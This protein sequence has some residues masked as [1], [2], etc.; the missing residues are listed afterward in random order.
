MKRQILLYAMPFL[1]LHTQATPSKLYNELDRAMQS[2]QAEHQGSIQDGIKT[3]T[4]FEAFKRQHTQDFNAYVEAQTAEYDA[5]RNQLIK[6]W[7]EAV[8]SDK[9]QFVRYAEDDNSRLDLDFANNVLTLSVKHNEGTPPTQKEVDELFQK[10]LRSEQALLQT[11]A[12]GKTDSLVNIG[13]EK[14]NTKLIN[15]RS[16]AHALKEAIREIKLQTQIQAQA[17]EKKYD[18]KFI[19]EREEQVTLNEL[20]D[21]KLGLNKIEQKR[22]RDLKEKLPDIISDTPDNKVIS[23]YKIELPKNN[24]VSKRAEKY[25]TSIKKQSDRFEIQSETILAV[26]HTESHFNPMA[27]S[28]IPAFGLMQVVPT[29]A[30]VDVNRFLYDIDAPM[31]AP[32]LYVSDN[33]IEAGAAYLHLLD[34]RYL[35]H[36]NDPQSRKYCMIAAY[37]TGA[38]NVAKAFNSDGS[39]NIFRASK[40]INTMTPSRVLEVLSANLPYD[41]TKKYIHKVL[42]KESLYK[43]SEV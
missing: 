28:R 13:L 10:F 22:I 32:Y 16:Q 36:I 24:S 26:M 18:A 38:G 30:G 19:E 39:R 3:Q 2:W 1:A 35:K 31:S 21:D 34:Q 27:K 11:F 25:L 17:L 6:S 15:K 14:S 4:E 41:E 12:M 8:V 37:N 42:D 40:I 9:N 33:N 23:E 29:S 5:F 20:K 7:G 43:A